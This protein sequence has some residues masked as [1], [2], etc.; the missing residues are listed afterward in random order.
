MQLGKGRGMVGKV[1]EDV[2]LK[3]Q[4][5]CG[6]G[7]GGGRGW[8]LDGRHRREVRGLGLSLQRGGSVR[9]SGF[10]L[11]GLLYVIVMSTVERKKDERYIILALQGERKVCAYLTKTSS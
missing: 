11:V 6:G 3:E 8:S 2:W 10:G 4:L 1:W 7:R 9:R 5:W